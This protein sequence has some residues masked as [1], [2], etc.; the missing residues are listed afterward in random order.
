M[1]FNAV[2]LYPN[3]LSSRNTRGSANGKILT[4]PILSFQHLTEYI[5]NQLDGYS[6]L[7]QGISNRTICTFI[8]KNVGQNETLPITDVKEKYYHIIMLLTS[9]VIPLIAILALYANML[10]RL[11]K[12]SAAL[13][14]GPGP[15]RDSRNSGKNQENKKRVTRMII[16]VIIV[17]AVCWT[18]LQVILVLKAFAKYDD[19]Q[20]ESLVIIQIVANCLA[21]SNSCLNPLLYAFFSPN[22]RTAF[23]QALSRSSMR[24][25]RGLNP[26]RPSNSQGRLLCSKDNVLETTGNPN[27]RRM[28]RPEN[29]GPRDSLEMVHIS[30]STANSSQVMN[31]LYSAS[32]L[33]N[34]INKNRLSSC[35]ETQ[36]V[37][38]FSCRRGQHQTI[39][40]I[41]RKKIVV[42]MKVWYTLNTWRQ[43]SVMKTM[44]YFRAW[45]LTMGQQLHHQK[46][47]FFYHPLLISDRYYIIIFSC[48]L[49]IYNCW[50]NMLIR[51]K[52]IIN[53]YV[54]N[55]FRLL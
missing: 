34:S 7:F 48:C 52:N 35:M 37:F 38:Y 16:A 47:R 27:D 46:N 12:G 25:F 44:A 29:N 50:C 15:S 4:R 17:F 13:S 49:F 20:Y 45:N 28:S 6:Q 33:I 26:R 42:Q 55:V 3:S 19:H 40:K 31:N 5:Q 54:Q 23:V 18:P 30:S 2:I 53:V 21:H 41:I 39:Q 22:F 24:D 10:M 14:Q 51:C 32:Y 11:W 36:Y 1:G 8:G 43:I 9:L